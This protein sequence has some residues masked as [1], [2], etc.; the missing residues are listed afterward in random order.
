MPPSS[1]HQFKTCVSPARLLTR[2]SWRSQLPGLQ[3]CPAGP[4][5]CRSTVHRPHSWAGQT[6]GWE[7]AAAAGAAARATAA[8]GEAGTAAAWAAAAR[9]PAW[10]A[11]GWATG[12]WGWEAG[13]WAG[14]AEAGGWEAWEQ[15]AGDCGLA[16]EGC[17]PVAAGWLRLR[18]A[19]AQQPGTLQQGGGQQVLRTPP[20]P[21]QGRKLGGVRQLAWLHHRHTTPA[22]HAAQCCAPI[23]QHSMLSHPAHLCWQASRRRLPSR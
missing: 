8:W 15:A 23:C 20:G 18:E 5:G 10:A 16:V 22:S 21:L 2:S 7:A 14:A 17:E 3:T 19:A 12:A 1:S 6:A 4:S 13:A 9:Q 11:A